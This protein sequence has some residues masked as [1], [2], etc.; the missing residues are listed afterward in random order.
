MK[1]GFRCK[2]TILEKLE[3]EYNKLVREKF[4]GNYLTPL[5][6]FDS[7]AENKLRCLLNS[8]YDNSRSLDQAWKTC[9]GSLY[10]FAV[11]KFIEQIISKDPNLKS[12]FKVV[13]GDETL[14]LHREQIVIKN[15]CEIL[16][17]VDIIIVEKEIDSVKVVIS[18]KTSLRERLTE[19]AFWKRELEKNENTRDIKL[20]FVTTDKDNELKI[21]TNRYIL[22][23]VIDC[24]FITDPQ[25]YKNLIESYKKKYG[26]REDYNVLAEKVCSIEGMESFLKK[27]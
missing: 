21:D 16:P 1:R 12:R 5:Q 18:C 13:M 25:K 10:E 7:I 19:T 4:E 6:K 14:A 20:A 26:N 11:F 27:L 8:F 9:K 23:H 17:D 22:L 24:T 15:W 2:Y 3:N